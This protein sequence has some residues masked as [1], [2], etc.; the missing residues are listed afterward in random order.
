M[1]SSPRPASAGQAKN[2]FVN[3]LARLIQLHRNFED[4]L[5]SQGV[6]LLERSI[7]ATY[8]D[9]IEFGATDQARMLLVRA[10]IE[11]DALRKE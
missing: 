9:C 10:G 7:Y 4:D 1:P 5:N 6:R 2:V 8:L 11:P 3:R